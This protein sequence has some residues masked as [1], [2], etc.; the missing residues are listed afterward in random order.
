MPW[1]SENQR[2]RAFRM[3]QARMAQNTVA[4]H[5][6]V[7]QN[8]IQSLWRRFQQS[9]NTR[10]W[11]RSMHHHVTSLRQDNHCRLLHLRNRFKSARLTARCIP[12][13]RPISSWTV[14]NRLCECNIRPRRPAVRPILVQHHRTAIP[15]WCRRHM[16]VGI[17]DC[18]NIL[19]TN[20]PS[21]IYVAVT[22]VIECIVALVNGTKTPMVYNVNDSVEV[23][24][25]CGVE[26]QQVDGPLYKLLM[27]ISLAYA[28]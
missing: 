20:K 21:F 19:F 11:P 2:N 13:L 1:L 15:A 3:V 18:T 23:A 7:H 16:F 22:A 5:F 28:I 10:N 26:E 27:E 6:G 24:L 14:R 25:C 4:R 9:G 17:Q 8:T 12:G